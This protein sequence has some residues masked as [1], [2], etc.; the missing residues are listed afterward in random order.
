MRAS[1]AAS[2]RRKLLLL[3]QNQFGYHI[4]TYYY[5]KYLRYQFDITYLCWDY[6]LPTMS[7]GK[8]KV[9][10]VPRN[11]NVI[12][13]NARYLS[14][15]FSEIRSGEYDIHFVKYF[16]AC[17][18][19]GVFN[20]QKLFVLDIRSG[21][22]SGRPLSRYLFD[23]VIKGESLF[24][25]NITVIS[26]SLAKRLGL[27]KKT[28]ILP[29]GADRLSTETKTFE[30]LK[31]LYV[32]TLVQRNI[33]L[34]LLG[35]AEF[36]NEFK[37]KIDVY[38]TI[39]GGGAHGEEN[40]LRE[41]VESK[42]LSAVVSICGRI[43]HDQLKPYFDSHNVGVSFVPMTDY[44]DVQ[45]VTK[46]F[47]YLLSGMPVIATATSENR[48]VVNDDNGVLVHDSADSF[49]QGLKLLH[50]RDSFYKSNKISSEVSKYRWEP[51]VSQLSNYLNEICDSKRKA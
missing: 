11:G 31:L 28:T 49:Y 38:Y 8:V 24:F 5:C 42:K 27:E 47:E 26:Q 1:N 2:T 48:L 36:Y 39:I 18:L 14:A 44:F 23:F 10:S 43:P 20:P 21:H 34:S 30:S 33:D 29:L 45:P 32:G 12:H 51:I 35:F 4:D 13:R 16:R 46:T 7:M 22:I 37:N 25:K 3:C 50:A 9:L 6:G 15:A 17:F 40:K 41:V 19:L